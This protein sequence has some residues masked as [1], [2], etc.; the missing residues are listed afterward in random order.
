VKCHLTNEG[1]AQYGQVYQ[2]FAGIMNNRNYQAL[3]DFVPIPD[4]ENAA[5]Y[6][7]FADFVDAN[8]NEIMLFALVAKHAGL[9]PGN[10][11]NSPINVHRMAGLSSGLFL[12]DE[13]GCP[14]NPIDANPNHPGCN[15]QTPQQRWAAFLNG[16]IQISYNLDGVA[17]WNGVANSSC[18]DPML[19]GQPSP[20]RDGANHPDQCGPMGQRLLNKLAHPIDGLILRSWINAD[21]QLQGG[22]AT[23]ISE[24]GSQTP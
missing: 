15:G 13:E 4:G 12:T 9:N 16:Q 5:D 20:L 18:S 7:E 17:E 22:A 10:T 21:G 8:N 14:V 23:V 11:L 2:L 1:M 24:Q 6:A 19:T 3:D